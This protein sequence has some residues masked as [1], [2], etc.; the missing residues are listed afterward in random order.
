MPPPPPPISVSPNRCRTL[1]VYA[2]QR[3]AGDPVFIISYSLHIKR[4]F[5]CYC[6]ATYEI[7]MDTNTVSTS[8]FRVTCGMQFLG[9][10]KVHSLH[11]DDED[12]TCVVYAVWLIWL[13]ACR[14]HIFCIILHISILDIG[15]VTE[16]IRLAISSHNFP[17]KVRNGVIKK[18]FDLVAGCPDL[19]AVEGVTA[20]RDGAQLTLQCDNTGITTTMQCN[21]TEWSGRRPDCSQRRKNSF[22]KGL[23][24]QNILLM[25]LGTQGTRPKIRTIPLLAFD[26]S[27]RH[28]T[29]V[30]WNQ[31]DTCLAFAFSLLTFHMLC[32]CRRKK[33]II[34]KY[35]WKFATE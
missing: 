6:F 20:T 34:I 30:D 2:C 25:I 29:S 13:T 3:C 28:C 12:I 16:F 17:I 33:I 11:H 14:S 8:Q 5:H 21:G 1:R 19:A 18:M 4:I 24:Q 9:H 10:G 26:D 15:D 31:Q 32:K 35:Q 23:R 7:N 27:W 22:I